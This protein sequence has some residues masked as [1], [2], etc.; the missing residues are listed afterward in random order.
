MS[1]LP[2]SEVKI[3][4]LRDGGFLIYRGFQSPHSFNPPA[5]ATSTLG[6]ALHYVA[7]IMGPNASSG[8]SLADATKNNP[9][10]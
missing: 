8:R 5:K 2:E 4:G 7:E 3:E 1:D 6:E 9:P 10:E